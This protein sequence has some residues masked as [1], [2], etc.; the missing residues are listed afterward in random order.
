M[1]FDQA[2]SFQT[3][4]YESPTDLTA[5]KARPS[6][7]SSSVSQTEQQQRAARGLHL[8]T[9]QSR[10]V[11]SPSITESPV[12][13]EITALGSLK[14]KRKAVEQVESS[15]SEK[16]VRLESQ[17]Q[18]RLEL[19]E[20]RGERRAWQAAE[21]H[22]RDMAEKAAEKERELQLRIDTVDL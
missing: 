15:R 17:E 9:I 19:A 20:A 16:M 13:G 7:P 12:V 11:A 8:G 21:S 22:A 3:L 1:D 4:L 14:G 5:R 6:T 10:A 18:L 2:V